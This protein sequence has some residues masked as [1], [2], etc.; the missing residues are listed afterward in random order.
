MKILYWT[1]LFWP[2]IGGIEILSERF[3]PDMKARGYDFILVTSLSEKHLKER[4][5]YKGIEIFRYPFGEAIKNNNL[6]LMTRI[7][8]NLLKLKQEFQPDVVHLNF[9]GP[10]VFY[11]F[12]TEQKYSVPTIMTIHVPV[13]QPT[14]RHTLFIQ[15]LLRS[16]WVATVSEG[17]LSEARNSAPEI[18]DRSSVIYNGLK[19]VDQQDLHAPPTQNRILCLGRLV[20]EKGFDVALQAFSL[21][22]PK[23]SEAVL[24]IAGDGPEKINLIKMAERLGVGDSV[25]FTGWI[26][27]DRIPQVMQQTNLLVIPSRWSEPFPLVALESAILGKAVIAADVGGLS[28]FFIH[29]NT[30]LLFPREDVRKLAEAME[31]LLEDP[32]KGRQFGMASHARVHEC[33]G[34]EKF[35]SSYDALYQKLGA[36]IA[37]LNEW[38]EGSSLEV[39]KSFKRE[40]AG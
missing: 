16:D 7:R 39:P 18:T 11:H 38:N 8:K 20:H 37:V 29:N 13:P 4:D 32:E 15:S 10:S 36:P 25:K 28:E 33:F 17:I 31:Y 9:S 23:H 14:P 2:H 40:N 24:T 19:M 26:P 22:R 35:L 1:E 27:P 34:W 5:R 6:V 21:I 30:G 12:Q 3:I